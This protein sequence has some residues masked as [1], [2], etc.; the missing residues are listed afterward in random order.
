MARNRHSVITDGL[1]LQRFCGKMI[2]AFGHWHLVKPSYGLTCA[3]CADVPMLV[4]FTLLYVAP[5]KKAGR[6]TALP[7]SLR[8]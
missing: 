3:V 1:G 8:F 2:G 4:Y 6:K 7:L 5:K